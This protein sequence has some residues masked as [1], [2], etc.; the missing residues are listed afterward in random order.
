MAI[1]KYNEKEKQL[2][3]FA[4]LVE[5][6]SSNKTLKVDGT[7]VAVAADIDYAT[8]SISISSFLS[9]NI[10]SIISDYYNN[11]QILSILNEYYTS[12]EISSILSNYYN[13]VDYPNGLHIKVVEKLPEN[14]RDDTLYFVVGQEPPDYGDLPLDHEELLK[15]HLAIIN[16]TDGS[17]PL[18][19][20]VNEF[21][22]IDQ[23]TVLASDL[24]A[25]YDGKNY[26]RI[27]QIPVK[28][29]IYLKGTLYNHANSNSG[30]GFYNHDSTHVPIKIAGNLS[31]IKNNDIRQIFYT[32]YISNNNYKSF[33][34]IDTSELVLRENDKPYSNASACYGFYNL[35]NVQ[36][37][38]SSKLNE[39]CYQGLFQNS[40]LLKTPPELPVTELCT[41]CYWGLF[42]TCISLT[43]AP[44]LPATTLAPWCYYSMFHDTRIS[45]IKLPAKELCEGCYSHIGQKSDLTCVEVG[46]S[47]WKYVNAESESSP[48]HLWLYNVPEK[49]V[50]KCPIALGTNF[51]IMRGYD[52]C[53]DGWTVINTDVE[54]TLVFQLEDKTR[55][56][57]IGMQPATKDNNLSIDLKYSYDLLNWLDFDVNI[58]TKIQLNTYNPIC[59]IKAG[60]AGNVRF[61]TSDDFENHETCYHFTTTG[62]GRLIVYGSLKALFGSTF[63]PNI[64]FPCANL[65]YGCSCIVDASELSLL[66]SN[67]VGENAGLFERCTNL[68][69]TPNIDFQELHDFGV[70]Q[71]S[72][73]PDAYYYRMFKD[74]TNLSNSQNIDLQY[75]TLD[76]LSGINAGTSCFAS[77]YE[78]C[79]KLEKLPLSSSSKR[80]VTSINVNAYSFASMFKNCTSLTNVD[81]I[82]E[83]DIHH[84]LANANP[85][86]N[87]YMSF[88]NMFENC[89]GIT[90]T[91]GFKWFDNAISSNLGTWNEMYKG[92]SNLSYIRSDIWTN[93]KTF[94]NKGNTV[95][96][97]SGVAN[98]GI[99][100]IQTYLDKYDYNDMLIGPSGIPNG[101]IFTASKP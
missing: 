64:K 92:C 46:F 7:N 73:I 77:M 78:N 30:V 31:A 47:D 81:Y 9:S 87:A 26:I 76:T 33:E 29:V 91:P 45:S 20:M 54:N 23:K 3:K 13:K 34:V 97:L 6:D 27:G 89:I 83:I 59:Y 48:T 52:F 40:Q 43:S 17:V 96:W 84:G 75:Y 70:E 15:D 65:F 37:S 21:L 8:I 72:N 5:Y 49:G 42:N 101:W 85:I 95:N 88:A 69:A 60:L 62:D 14:V 53:P 19:L 68:T 57:D 80:M 41:G 4:S 35:Q 51:S 38:L 22:N 93:D 71:K 58:S 79:E 82:K 16:L 2:Q 39:W 18:N 56:V 90:E 63:N 74:C 86:P 25:T 36:K 44:E 55:G 1:Y 99:F 98:D 50:F 24:S 67:A 32:N 66:D 94:F 100:S 61:T 12:S 28:N 11:E 10:S